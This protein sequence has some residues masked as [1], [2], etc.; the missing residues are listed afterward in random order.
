MKKWILFLLVLTVI[1]CKEK[2]DEEK[3]I[4]RRDFVELLVDLHITDAIA[5]NHTINENFGR[6]D[7]A[8][9]YHTVL[10][11][12]GFTK[13]QMIR[14]MNYYSSD[15]EE[16]VE[17]YDDVFSRLSKQADEAKELYSSTS[18][19]RTYRIWKAPKNRYTAYGDS[20]S[21]PEPFDIN[22]DTTGT[23]VLTAEVRMVESDSSVNPR[24]SAYFYNPEDDDPKKR[25]YFEEVPIL[26][27][28]FTREYTLIKTMKSPN[29]TR[30][31][32]IIPNQDNKDSLFVKG[33]EIRH[34]RVGMIMP[35][36]KR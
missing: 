33:I 8:I 15:P 2:N 3:I 23:Y 5:T 27:A 19:S 12:H 11:S 29:L 25:L 28:N 24:I 20:I 34:L 6:L 17:I 14:S 22:V 35:K 10:E 1:A 7:S 16:L 26:K 13:E 21:Y 18:A 32:I 36:R 30:L 9:L 4:P 31:K